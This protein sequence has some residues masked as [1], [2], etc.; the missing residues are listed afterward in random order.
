VC[1]FYLCSHLHP[2]QATNT[3]THEMSAVERMRE[4]K[5]SVLAQDD[6][7]ER[8]SGKAFCFMILS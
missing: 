1:T 3:Q 5:F 6:D 8:R 2:K 7:D 4:R